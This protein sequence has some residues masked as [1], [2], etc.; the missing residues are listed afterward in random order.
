MKR[1]L[2]RFLV[3][4]WAVLAAV[5]LLIQVLICCT[6]AGTI[7]KSM[8]SQ[9]ER[10]YLEK[11]SQ[12]LNISGSDKTDKA[13]M[14]AD[15]QRVLTEQD[16]LDYSYTYGAVLRKTDGTLVGKSRNM[17]YATF[18]KRDG[19]QEVVP[20][21]FLT[22][23]N[24]DVGYIMLQGIL[25]TSDSDTLDTKC[26]RGFW[27]DGYFYVTYLET[28]RN[29]VKYQTDEEIPQNAETIFYQVGPGQE[30]R[31]VSVE[32][33]IKG[34]VAEAI[35]GT[36]EL[37]DVKNIDYLSQWKK[38][39]A[40]T[41]KLCVTE[42]PYLTGEDFHAK[43]KG[44][45]RTFVTGSVFLRDNLQTYGE[46]NGLLYTYGAEFS[47]LGLALEDMLHRGTLIFPWLFVIFGGVILTSLYRITLE[48]K[49]RG[50]Q[51]EIQRQT[52]ALNYAQNA[53]S[54]RREM[55]SAI[56]HELKTPVAVLSSYAEALQEDIEPEKQKKYLGVLRQE[57]EKMDRMVLELL[58]LS[59]LEAGK[60]QLQRENFDLKELVEEIIEPLKESI[61]EKQL[62]VEIRAGEVLINADRYRFGQIIENFMTNAIRHTPDGGEVLI[63][64]GLDGDTLSVENQGSR[65]SPN[66]LQKVWDTFWQGDASRNSRGS[67]LGLSICK[68][69]M[70]LHGGSCKAE[71]TSSGVRFSVNL[72]ESQR[73][74]ILRTMPREDL[75]ELQYPIAQESTTIKL[76]FAQLGLLEGK[77]L[78]REIKAG[79]IKCG[80]MTVMKESA[81]VKPGMVVAWQDYR[82]TVYLDNDI[83]RRA[84]LANQFQVTGRLGN[85]PSYV[86]SSAQTG[87]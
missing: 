84:L 69:I 35:S 87:K 56:A 47:P 82:I 30:Y 78:R 26:F 8:L 62:Q 6:T 41:E 24:A 32:K 58:D 17:L 20:M 12:L 29:Y 18:V 21:V 25:S 7:Q 63:R 36:A 81:R 9:L 71:N 72:R 14:V 42:L 61:E 4:V 80:E 66:Q 1:Q 40:L 38:T 34:V 67:G 64:V 13:A 75:I 68:T 22:D 77:K 76:I 86:G 48:K 85:T 73:P 65:L 55:V 5:C 54:S 83:K 79:T 3:A 2:D 52:Q 46:S 19:G 37:Y 53:E 23:N 31:R 33:C 70:N 45:F 15:Y 51:D 49:L 16:M 44:L 43:K 50:Y 10:N 39:D 59:R 28:G 27:Q 60:Y 57:T 74:V 11:Y